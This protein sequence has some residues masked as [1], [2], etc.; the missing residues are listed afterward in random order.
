MSTPI[1]GVL[2]G[3]SP[4]ARGLLV[5]PRLGRVAPGIIP[6]RAGVTAMV[7]VAGS[8]IKDHPRSR[9]VYQYDEFLATCS[10]GSSPLARGLRDPT[11]LTVRQP[12]IIPARAGFTLRHDPGYSER[13]DHPRSRGVYVA[14]QSGFPG[15]EGSSPLARGL[16]RLQEHAGVLHRIIPAR[17]GFT[18]SQ[19]VPT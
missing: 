15:H 1:C 7:G 18:R 14:V 19:H 6:A 9:G 2:S 4:L 11:R 12:R 17:A 8:G 3:S 13:P 5:V 10:L 16:L